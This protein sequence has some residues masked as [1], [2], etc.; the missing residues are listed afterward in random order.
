MTESKE[1]GLLM[2]CMAEEVRE[3][4]NI[5]HSYYNKSQSLGSTNI[6]TTEG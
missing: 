4:Q 5:C 2:E 1:G 3:P 6:R